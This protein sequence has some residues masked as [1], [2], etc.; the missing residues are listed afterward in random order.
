MIVPLKGFS[1]QN[2]AVIHCGIIRT[3]ILTFG[4]I[5]TE[6]TLTAFKNLKYRVGRRI[7]SNK[8]SRFIKHKTHSVSFLEQTGQLLKGIQLL[9]DSFKGQHSHYIFSPV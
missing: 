2:T 3:F 7:T 5:I 4:N 8:Q 6:E 9:T 1:K